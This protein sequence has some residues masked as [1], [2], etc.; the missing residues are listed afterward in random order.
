MSLENTPVF[1][2]WM[3][4]LSLVKWT[5]EALST[6]EFVGLTFDEPNVSDELAHNLHTTL[7]Y[8]I[9]KATSEVPLTFFFSSIFATILH[10]LYKKVDLNNY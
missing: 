1:L 9:S 4:E 8:F 6:N 7:P 2:R 3:P 5:F 10:P